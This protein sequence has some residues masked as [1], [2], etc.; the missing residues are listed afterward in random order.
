MHNEG[1]RGLRAPAAAAALALSLAACGG[2]AR[3]GGAWEGAVDTLANGAVLV[4][5]PERGLWGEDEGWRLVEEVRIG[6]MEVEGP[7][8]F[9][10]I[11]GVAAD[12]AGRIYVADAQA[13]EV[14]VFDAE[15]RHVRTFGR[16][17]GGP[18]EFEQIAGMDWGP[19]G[20][21]W[22]MDARNSR[23]AVFDTTGS[24]VT[25]HRRPGGFVM[26]PWPGGFDDAGNLYD[27]NVV[28]STPGEFRRGF[29]RYDGQMEPVDTFA[30]PEYE[31]S[32][33]DLVDDGGRRRMS[34]GIPFTPGQSWRLSPSGDVWIGIS[35]RYRLHR[36]S[37]AGDT[38]QIVE[39]PYR[40]VA[41]SAAERA[42]EVEQ[43]Q[44][45]VEMG[46][47]VDPARIPSTKPAFGGFFADADGYLWVEPA[48]ADGEEGSAYDIFDPAGRYLG[49]V[50][51][52][53]EIRAFTRP[54]IR[55]GMMY[56][57]TRD[58][59]EVPYV[60]RLRIEGRG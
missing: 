46:G 16:K 20:N 18:G 23:F 26:L 47:K 27:V 41:V 25:S 19:D 24:F 14:R 30:I 59:L 9:G 37:F 8:L 45:F 50:T 21:L 58:E 29:L 32:T 60:V 34:L 5:N 36:V 40:P 31:G 7:E 3:A 43:L 15:G 39:K 55:D 28:S 11:A 44:R 38:V 1:N 33:F 17:G 54:V 4:S 6:S 51:S 56:A 35:D 13:H 57:V 22:V 12:G 2:D 52:Q 48:R 10:D 42:R 49:R 53:A